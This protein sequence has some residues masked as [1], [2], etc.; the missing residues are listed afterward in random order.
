M[1]A[2]RVLAVALAVVVAGCGDDGPPKVA[3]TVSGADIPSERV[4]RLTSQWV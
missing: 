4:E 2:L 3:A 1:R